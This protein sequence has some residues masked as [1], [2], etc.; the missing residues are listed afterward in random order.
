MVHV[1]IA[2][3]HATSQVMVVVGLWLPWEDLQ[4]WFI[5]FALPKTHFGTEIYR[6]KNMF[7][8]SSS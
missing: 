8:T 5:L 4:Q 6:W 7:G 2:G 3:S 1:T